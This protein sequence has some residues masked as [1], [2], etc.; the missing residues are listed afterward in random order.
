MRCLWAGLL[1]LFI[2][3][4]AWAQ[5]RGQVLS[6][7]F[8]NHYRPDCWTPM[9][10]QLT[11][12]SEDSVD[13]QIQV[14]QEDLD[15]DKVTYTQQVTLGGNVEGKSATTENFWVYFKPRSTGGGL[16]D[17]AMAG[18]NL[19]T[20][21]QELKVFL[22]TKNGKQ[23]TTLPITS[24]ILSADPQHEALDTTRGRKLILVVTDGTDRP[25]IPDYTPMRGVLEDLETVVLQPR[26]LPS[27]VRGYE[28]VDG[29]VWMDADANFLVSG[30]HTPS[31]EAIQQWVKHGGNLVICQPPEAFKIRPFADANMLPVGGQLNGEWTIPMADRTGVDVLYRVAEGQYPDRLTQKWPDVTAAFKVARVPALRDTKVDEWMQWDDNGVT[32]YTPWL[33]R[34]GVGL[35]AVTWVAQDLGNP[36][37]TDKIRTGWRFVWDRVFGWNNATDIAEDYQI[38]SNDSKWVLATAIDLGVPLLSFELTNDAMLLLTLAGFFLGT[39]VIVVAGILPGFLWQRKK[40]HLNWFYFA[41]AAMIATVLTVLLVKLVVRGPPKLEHFSF[42]RY[43]SGEPTGVV[44]S[45][46]TLYVRQDGDQQIDLL[47]TAPHEV[48]DIS[49]FSKHPQYVGNDDILPAYLEYQIPV[50]EPSDAQSVSVTIPFRSTSKKLQVHWV[51]EIKDTIYV[52]A[53][54]P[55]LK[56]AQGDYIDGTVVNRTGF[57][58]ADIYFVFKAPQA[59]VSDKVDVDDNDMIIYVPNWPK[60]VLLKLQDVMAGANLINADK[61]QLGGKNPAWGHSNVQGA[62]WQR[63]WQL[64]HDDGGNLNYIEPLLTDFSRILPWNTTQEYQRYEFLRR[65]ARVLD[66]SPAINAGKLVICAMAENKTPL[67]VPLNVAGSP[68]AGGGKTIFQFVLP[69][70]RSDVYH[71]P[72]TAPSTRE[73][74]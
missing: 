52:P 58:L 9:L 73:I 51:G 1:I 37:L 25:I 68:V 64:H 28:A 69:L 42:V 29:I 6:I 12:Q 4:A 55:P 2:P 50:H 56:L 36:A 62:Q 65:E 43:A 41:A 49:P 74:Q 39:Y 70:N 71:V 67:P 14:V 44:D 26:D 61:F 7:G 3:T 5:A 33:A 59:T 20:L 17:A 23:I 48:S 10:V 21:N 34:R 16:P 46:I 53:G 63:F 19:N 11:S 22:C 45:R 31:L 35:G 72:A 13:Y 38:P 24:T 60:D 57:D 27:D 40:S 47:N 32:S 30:T 54:M 8:D 18:T 15:R 66:L